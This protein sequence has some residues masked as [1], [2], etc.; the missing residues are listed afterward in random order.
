MQKKIYSPN[1][2]VDN[3][4]CC[5]SLHYNGDNSYLLVNGK[6]VNKFKAKNSELIMCVGVFE[7]TMIQIVVKTQDYMEVLVTLVLIIVLLQ[8]MKY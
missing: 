8:I 3:K 4:I 2:T 6:E 5:L 7:K 1:F